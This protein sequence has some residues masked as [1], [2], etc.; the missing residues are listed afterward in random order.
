MNKLIRMIILF[1]FLISSTVAFAIK[2][3]SLYE[4]EVPVATQSEMARKAV[5]PEALQQVL[6]KVTGSNQVLTN[7]KIKLEQANLPAL[8]QE[9]SYAPSIS[10][11]TLKV[12]FDPNGVNDLLK[13]AG[14]ATWGI[15][16]P[17]LLIWL[18]H[19]TPSQPAQIIDNESTENVLAVLQENARQRGIP[20]LLPT[21]DLATLNQVT[22]ADVV[23]PNLAVL[24]AA[25]KRYNTDNMLT[26]SITELGGQFNL[27][28]Q[29]GSANWNLQAPTLEELL[30]TFINQL[31]E[32]LAGQ[33]STVVS[34]T[35]Q[36]Q[37]T[38]KVVGITH[39]DDFRRL[40]QYLKRLPPV[41][42]IE[43]QQISGQEV[44][45]SLT[46]RSSPQSLVQAISAETKLTAT[47]TAF[48]YQWNP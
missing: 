16:R 4:A 9:F 44:V 23:T 37:V 15:E 43:P 19:E 27:K 45:L 8:L 28:A 13:T 3:K 11:Y 35:I 22:V 42:D 14:V 12:K 39:H 6:V 25:A 2:V 21:L 33:Y 24:Q 20:I 32:K 30:K 31:A 48:T 7:P 1:F 5:L 41:A 36:G 40:M 17:L 10:G 18:V 46:L 29:M 38:L 26:M 47:S 34:E